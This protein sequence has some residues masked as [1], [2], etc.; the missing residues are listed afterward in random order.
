MTLL[1]AAVL[2]AT[3]FIVLKSSDSR[4]DAQRIRLVVTYLERRGVKNMPTQLVIEIPVGLWSHAL[5]HTGQ[6]RRLDIIDGEG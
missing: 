4:L 3:D 5:G 2:E 1:P 6:Y